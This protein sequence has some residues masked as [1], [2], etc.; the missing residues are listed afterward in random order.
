MLS[1]DASLVGIHMRLRPSME[2][3]QAYEDE[4]Y[5]EIA[6]AFYKPGRM[7]LNQ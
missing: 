3:F 2:K 1:V 4:G 5:L 6:D 7:H